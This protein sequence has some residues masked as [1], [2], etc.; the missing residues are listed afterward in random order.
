[1]KRLIRLSACLL[2]VCLLVLSCPVLAA[3]PTITVE[4]KQVAA[5][6]TS[7]TLSFTIDN[8]PGLA[9]MMIFLEYDRALKLTD[10]VEGAG[11][12]GADAGRRQVR[13]SLRPALG[14]A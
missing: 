3:Q 9:G 1:M 13:A 2:A 6:T 12:S 4:S 5:G 10:V 14:R 11:Q 7:V 8:N